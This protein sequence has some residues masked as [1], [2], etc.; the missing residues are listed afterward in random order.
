VELLH[1]GPQQQ[2]HISMAP[3]GPDKAYAE[4]MDIA[5]HSDATQ[6]QKA[7]ALELLAKLRLKFPQRL[8][9]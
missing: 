7:E 5:N 1:G 3:Y 6:D 8:A 2:V 9:S 4:L